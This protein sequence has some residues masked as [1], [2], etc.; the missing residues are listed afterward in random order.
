M[1]VETKKVTTQYTRDSKLK[2]AHSY[3][4]I[5][6]VVVMQC[7]N[8]KSL[9]ER[10][11]GNMDRKRINNNYF[12]V[13]SKCNSKQFAQ[14]KGVERRTIWNLPVSSDLKI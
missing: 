3:S 8:C 13:C 9:F 7:D 2:K 4:R 1:I 11:Q 6:T 5:K 10:T 12:H 14:Q